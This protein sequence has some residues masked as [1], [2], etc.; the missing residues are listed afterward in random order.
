MT[1][2]QLQRLDTLSEAVARVA[3][4]ELNP[5]NWT[6]AG[7]QMAAQSKDERGAR[8]FDKKSAGAT[9]GLLVKIQQ[10]IALKSTPESVK[11]AKLLQKEIEEA[12]FI[13]QLEKDAASLFTHLNEKTH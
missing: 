9:L 4:D 6:A 5:Q 12:G 1:P 7:V 13:E 11:A 8:L 3:I 10:I 2:E